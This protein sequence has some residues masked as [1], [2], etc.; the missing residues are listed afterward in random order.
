M[1]VPLSMTDLAQYKRQL[2]KLSEDLSKFMEEFKNLFLTYEFTWGNIQVT[3]S[4]SCTPEEK[5][6]IW[7]EA[8]GQADKLQGPQPTHCWA[9]TEVVPSIDPNWKSQRRQ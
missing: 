2:G 8:Q 7:T 6:R 9:R 5:W 3:L 1:Y 4:T